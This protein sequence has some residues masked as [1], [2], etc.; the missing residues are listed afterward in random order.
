MPLPF[1]SG[2]FICPPNCT[3]MANKAIDSHEGYVN[4]WMDSWMDESRN[5]YFL[6]CPYCMK[7]VLPSTYFMKSYSPVHF[8]INFQSI[9]IM[10]YVLGRVDIS[11][12]YIF[13]LTPSSLTKENRSNSGADF[14]SDREWPWI[15]HA[16]SERPC[17]SLPSLLLRRCEPALSACWTGDWRQNP[18]GQSE[19]WELQGPRSTLL[20]CPCGTPLTPVTPDISATT[21][22]YCRGGA[23]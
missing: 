2:I 16:D 4:Q 17:V 8:L 1:L 5:L 7:K 13:H 10:K 11:R 6:K 3:D 19:P 23:L 12:E 22:G 14:Y 20:T 21:N 15:R 18:R 9:F